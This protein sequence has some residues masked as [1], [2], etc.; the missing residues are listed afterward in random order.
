MVQIFT[1]TKQHQIGD[2]Q[3]KQMLG[4]DRHLNSNGS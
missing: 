1:N 3:Q 2:A 4:L